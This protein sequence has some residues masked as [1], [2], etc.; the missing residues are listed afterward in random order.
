MCS[1]FEMFWCCW[2]RNGAAAV[3]MM[4]MCLRRFC[5]ACGLRFVCCRLKLRMHHILFTWSSPTQEMRWHDDTH[6]ATPPDMNHRPPLVVPRRNPSR[7]NQ[8]N[9]PER[10]IV[11][12]EMG[13]WNVHTE[14]KHTQ[15]CSKH[16]Q[17]CMPLD[18]S[19]CKVE[20]IAK[21]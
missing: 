14:L 13:S 3:D 8:T 2:W 9:A 18:T 11:Q 21:S 19:L 1:R 4:S 20:S 16:R 12:Q 7:A 10:V 6:S 15:W 5:V 17:R